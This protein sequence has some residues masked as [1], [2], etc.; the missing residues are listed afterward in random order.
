MSATLVGNA[1]RAMTVA[2]IGACVGLAAAA[3]PAAAAA[4]SAAQERFRDAGELA[5]RGDFPR[6]IALYESL[7]VA[8]NE[9][10]SLDW[11]RAQAAYAR[12]A[13]GEALWALLRARELDPS[14]RAVARDIE[15][16][17]EGANLDRAEIAPDPL[18]AVAR[19]AR[20]FRLDLIAVLLLVVSLGAHA[21]LKL[22]RG[23]R[24]LIPIAWTALALGLGVAAVPIA[25]AF[26]HPTGTVVRRGAPLLDAASPTAEATGTLREGE[27]LPILEASGPYVRVEDSSGARGWALATDVRPLTGPP[28]R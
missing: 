2:M 8:G 19:A 26:A 25:G 10:A 28:Q 13:M 12:G 16:L 9:T 20:R 17:R 18:A 14:D 21:G 11:N 3:R 23:A 22:R 1:R 4:T 5:R 7:A 27:V 6:A 15:R 24:G